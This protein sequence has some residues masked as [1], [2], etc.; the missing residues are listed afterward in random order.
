MKFALFSAA[1]SMATL[2]GLLPAGSVASDSGRIA[3]AGPDL[4]IFQ[5]HGDVGPVSTPGTVDYDPATQRYVL[6]GSGS[7][8]WAA[9]DEF[10]FVWRKLSG[11]FIVSADAE[12][13]GAGIDPHRKLGWMIRASLKHDA[14]YVDIALH[15]DGLTSLQYRQT[16][17]GETREII[18]EVKAPRVLQLERRDGRYIASVAREGERL[19]SVEFDEISLPEDVYVGLFISAHNADV[20]ETAHFSNVRITIPAPRG[21]RPYQDY[22]GSRLE[23]IELD[24][25][26]RLVLHTEADSLQAPNWSAD[27]KSLIYNRNG[28][29][30][31]FDLSTRAV[32]GIDTGFAIHNNNDHALSFDGARLGISHHSPDHDGESMVYTLPSTGG[33]PR[34]I[35]KQS[36]SYLHGWSPDGRWLVYTGGRDGNYDIYKIRS[37]GSGEEI[38]LTRDASLDDGPEYSPDGRYV[39]FNSARSGKMQIWRMKADGSAQEQVTRDEFNNWFPHI[40]PDG[41]TIVYLAYMPDVDAEDHPWYR[42]VYL[43]SLSVEGGEPKVLANLYGGQGTINVPSWSPDGRF[44]AFVSNTA[45]DVRVAR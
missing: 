43:M 8:I 6:S 16:E 29:L 31:R 4:G 13:T 22:I 20:V 7:N 19:S 38:R 37:D 10:H 36:P 2:L 1:I 42:H 12:F 33:I 39:Y 44:V 15:G 14:P 3:T 24:T 40:S 9:S 5:G 45:G 35:T 32:S 41:E 26:L 18:S 27:G 21:F 30:Y 11:D 23:I 25:A 17:G 28:R 34:L